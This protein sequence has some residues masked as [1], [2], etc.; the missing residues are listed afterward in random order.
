MQP[1]GLA[2]WPGMTRG[3]VSAAVRIEDQVG[4]SAAP[5]ADDKADTPPAQPSPGEI[6]PVWNAVVFRRSFPELWGQYLKDRYKTAYAVQKAFPG[7]DSKTARDWIG[8]KRDPSG[9]FVAVAV[10]RDPGAMQILGAV[11]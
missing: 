9:S 7:I 2:G 3:A 5:V 10:K 6:S 4:S 8:G 1:P 11:A